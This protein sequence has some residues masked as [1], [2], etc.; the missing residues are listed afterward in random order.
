MRIKD[1]IKPRLT[2]GNWTLTDKGN[3]KLYQPSYEP[4]VIQEEDKEVKIPKQGIHQD[5]K[6]SDNEKEI[7][8]TKERDY[9]ATPTMPKDTLEIRR[10]KSVW[11]APER[12]EPKLTG[13]SYTQITQVED[14]KEYTLG[15]CL[16]EVYSFM[17]RIKE[18]GKMV[19]PPQLRR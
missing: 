1:E 10:S 5:H 9:E 18:F 7:P 19:C 11:F 17:K 15:Y 2:F 6:D 14:L 12:L 8:V 16:A 3:N 4:T 13:K